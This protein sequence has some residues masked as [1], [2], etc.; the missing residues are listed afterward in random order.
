MQRST[1]LS[2]RS[3]GK[4]WRENWKWS[5]GRNGKKS[6]T[7]PPGPWIEPGTL[8]KR[9]WCSAA[10]QV[11]GQARS[12]GSLVDNFIR[13]AS[14][15]QHRHYLMTW[16]TRF[17]QGIRR[18]RHCAS[19]KTWK[20]KFNTRVNAK[21]YA[22]D[23]KCKIEGTWQRKGQD[24]RKWKWSFRRNGNKSQRLFFQFFSIC[25]S[26]ISNFPS[27][28]LSPFPPSRSLWPCA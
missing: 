25:Q 4:E 16:L 19:C 24:K 18:G 8:N 22:Y 26:F 21:K 12:P 6:Q 5:L 27:L 20:K 11:L 10:T 2:E 17:A 13:S 9:G 14:T 1:I 28:Y 3:N 15:S 7:L 23:F